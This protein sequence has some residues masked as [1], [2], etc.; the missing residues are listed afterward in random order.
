MKSGATAPDI[1]WAFN[2]ILLQLE[3]ATPAEQAKKAVVVFA[4]T[5][6]KTTLV[7]GRAIEPWRQIMY[8]IGEMAQNFESVVVVP[9]GNN[10]KRLPP[11]QKEID[12]FPALLSERAAYADYPGSRQGLVVVGSV[13]DAG[14]RADFSQSGDDIVWA[15]GAPITCLKNDVGVQEEG[16]SFSVGMVRQIPLHSRMPMLLKLVQPA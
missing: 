13:D 12:R 3:T 4:A 14:A 16:T 1:L 11:K 8:L 15:P 2:S 5:S 7:A 10:A 9:S 6:T